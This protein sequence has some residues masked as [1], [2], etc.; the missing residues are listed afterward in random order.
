M[1]MKADVKDMFNEYI[2]N[3]NIEIYADLEEIDMKKVRKMTLDRV[4]NEHKRKTS[5]TIRV[6]LIAA[7]LTV[8]CCAT[9]YAA[10][11]GINYK[12]NIGNQ[13]Y[14]CDTYTDKGIYELT[15]STYEVGT[16][17]TVASASDC[18]TLYGFKASHLPSFGEKLDTEDTQNNIIEDDVSIYLINAYKNATYSIAV[19]SPHKVDTKYVIE[20]KSAVI[21]ENVINGMAATYIDSDKSEG[22]NDYRFKIIV[23]KDEK[24]GAL[25][26]VTGNGEAGFDELEKIAAGIEIVKTDVENEYSEINFGGLIGILGWG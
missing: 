7:A 5:K 18:S 24:T 2:D 12:H 6:L 1:T 3:E 26:V 14:S 20:G 4:E 16:E 23:M 10:V 17:V 9:V 19:Y 13:T 15:D 11:S 21:K 22:S 8:L 25:L